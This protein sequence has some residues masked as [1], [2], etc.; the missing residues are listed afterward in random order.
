MKLLWFFWYEDSFCLSSGHWF[1]LSAI[2]Q[3]SPEDWDNYI[4]SVNNHPVSIVVNLAWKKRAPWKKGLR[5][6]SPNQIQRLQIPA[7]SCT[8][9]L[10]TLDSME[11]ALE[12]LSSQLEQ[13]AAFS[14]NGF[15]G[16]YFMPLIRKISFAPSVWWTSTMHSQRKADRQDMVEL[17]WSAIPS[18]NELEKLKTEGS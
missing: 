12:K 13:Y 14:H 2:G 10:G 17:F 18:P 5:Y 15:E 7:V 8:E 6:H 16:I 11:F 4:I 3:T 9:I 1:F